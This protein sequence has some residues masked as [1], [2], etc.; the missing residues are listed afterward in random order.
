MALQALR[1]Q[2]II[3]RLNKAGVTQVVRAAQVLEATKLFIKSELP[4]C[5][6]DLMPQYV[7]QEV[8]MIQS[9]NSNAAHLLR[10]QEQVLITYLK[11]ACASTIKRVQF[12]I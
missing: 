8:L 4:D 2:D 3:R 12:K 7:K 9:T 6:D 5:V 11:Q 1:Q 10:Q